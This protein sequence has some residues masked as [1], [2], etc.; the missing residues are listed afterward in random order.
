MRRVGLHRDG[1]GLLKVG[2]PAGVAA[3]DP[4]AAEIVARPGSQLI[5]SQTIGH[6]ECLP[7]DPDGLL[8][9]AAV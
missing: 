1:E 8:M 3:V 5:E 7:P 2:D 6:L 4:R 9:L